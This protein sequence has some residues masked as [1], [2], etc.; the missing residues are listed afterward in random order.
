MLASNLHARRVE[1][2]QPLLISRPTGPLLQLCLF[3]QLLRF[4]LFS[5]CRCSLRILFCSSSAFFF[6]ASS[7]FLKVSS[8]FFH[9]F[10]FGSH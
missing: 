7:S 1:S 4:C 3:S 10:A 5:L 8:I 6:L 9:S 2:N